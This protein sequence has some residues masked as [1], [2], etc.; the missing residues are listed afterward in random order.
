MKI[1]LGTACAL[2][3][4]T[5]VSPAQVP[6]PPV[7]VKPGPGESPVKLVR[8]DEAARMELWETRVGPIWIPA[9]G[10]WVVPNLDW[11]QAERRIYDHPSCRVHPGDVVLD[12]GAHVGFF[13]RLALRAGAAT[14]VAIEPEKQNLLALRRNF[15]AEIKSGKVKVVPQGVWDSAGRLALRLSDSSNDSHSVVYDDNRKSSES[16]EVTTID[17]L[18]R[19]LGLPRVDFIKM[20]IEGAERNALRGARRVISHWRPRMALSS[21]HLAGDPA[22]ISALA[23][24]FR[25]DYRTG[26]KDLVKSPH[27]AIVP[28]VLFFY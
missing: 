18:Q 10:K 8:T 16:I 15:E 25:P 28:K 23:W 27:G 21:Y 6:P 13:T 4:M 11:E 22:A 26:S 14:V 12:C 1:A 17:L 7:P 24:E 3:L 9:P 20:D 2:I 5:V 19:S